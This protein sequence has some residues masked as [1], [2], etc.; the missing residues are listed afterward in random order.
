M[1]LSHPAG[2]EIQDRFGWRSFLWPVSPVFLSML[3]FLTCHCQGY[4]PSSRGLFSFIPP[5]NLA[6][7]GRQGI[8]VPHSC[9]LEG[10]C[11]AVPAPPPA[12]LGRAQLPGLAAQWQWAG[13]VGK[14][15]PGFH[16]DSGFSLLP[17]PR[18]PVDM[19]IILPG[20]EGT[21]DIIE[22]N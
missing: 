7:G 1:C 11:P 14:Q 15:N 4:F 18:S 21:R 16:P 20:E 10:A 3:G 13:L 5:G 8:H 2:I 22:K 17:I 12:Q 9:Q 6:T 19:R